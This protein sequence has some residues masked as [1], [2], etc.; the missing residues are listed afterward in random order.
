MTIVFTPKGKLLQRQEFFLGTM[1]T[2]FDYTVNSNSN[3]LQLDL[4]SPTANSKPVRTVFEFTP[5]GGLRLKLLRVF[6]VP[7]QDSPGR[8]ELQTLT[9]SKESDKTTLLPDAKERY[10]DP[11]AQPQS[12]EESAE[13][14]Q[15]E[16]LGYPFILGAAQQAY[17][18]ENGTFAQTID[19]LGI[20]IKSETAN[21]R[22]QVEPQ[23]N[24]TEQVK[25][26]A[27]AK[28]PRLY[29][30]TAVVFKTKPK[31]VDY[32]VLLVTACWTE[33]PSLIAPEMPKINPE[34]R[35]ILCPPGSQQY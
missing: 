17:Y 3:S 9:F 23:G 1:A 22:Y 20:G 16:V 14:A 8:F 28:R 35:T 26:M 33:Q 30:I 21:Y 32:D 6:P 2:S 34:T 31:V 7:R 19:Q 27:Q 10:L 18:L 12:V 25:I 15:A 29:S 11:V 5:H 24:G 4:K 13:A